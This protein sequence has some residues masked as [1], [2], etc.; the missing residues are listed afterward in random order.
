MGLSKTD[1]MNMCPALLQQTVS[2]VCDGKHDLISLNISYILQCYSGDELLDLYD[3]TGGLSKTDLM[4]MCPALLQQTAS[5][6]CD[7]KHDLNNP[8]HI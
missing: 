7:G 5:G 8:Y 1:L 6:V 3:I 4:N 2:G